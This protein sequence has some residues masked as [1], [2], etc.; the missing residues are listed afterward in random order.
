MAGTKSLAWKLVLILNLLLI[1]LG[2]VSGTFFV[3][4]VRNKFLESTNG[5]IESS[6]KSLFD[7]VLKDYKTSTE[8]FKTYTHNTTERQAKAF[9]DIAFDLYRGDENRIKE[10]ISEKASKL[11]ER[12]KK[13]FETIFAITFEQAIKGIKAEIEQFRNYQME[14]A[15]KLVREMKIEIMVFSF[16]TIL[17]F[18]LFYHGYT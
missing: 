8:I 4:N 13:N 5:M 10:A 7:I 9:S 15:Q 12:S 1:L 3:T 2:V 14:Q 18:I 11:N 17:L 16:I 6:E